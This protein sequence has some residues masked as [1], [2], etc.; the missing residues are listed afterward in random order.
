MYDNHNVLVNEYHHCLP[1][2]PVQ[3]TVQSKSFL[4]VAIETKKNIF[5]LH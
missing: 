1:F 2:F 4:K 5:I 3:Y